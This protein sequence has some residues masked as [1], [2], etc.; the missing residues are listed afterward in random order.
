VIVGDGP[1]KEP[2]TRLVASRGLEKS[3]RLLGWVDQARVHRH[4]EEADVLAFPSIREF[5]GAVAIEAMAAGAVPIVM[6]Y[7]GT[8]ELVSASNGYLLEMG[9]RA[10]IIERLGK[11]LQQ[12]SADP[13]QLEARRSAGLRRVKTSFTWQAKAR[14]V[15][16]VYRWVLGARPDKPDFGMPLREVG[17]A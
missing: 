13:G 7:G 14:Q 3:V 15:L 8:G 5:G 4:L 17:D 2:L 6:D 1:E 12:I 10:S 16:E 9:P 11:L